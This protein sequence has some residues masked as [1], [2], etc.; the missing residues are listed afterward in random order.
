MN[1]SLGDHLT[2]DDGVWTSGELMD[3][4]IIHEV[5]SIFG[6]STTE[7][8]EDEE[9][10]EEEDC[11]E[12]YQQPAIKEATNA[13]DTLRRFFYGANVEVDC[14]FQ[15]LD[16]IERILAVVTTKAKKQARITDYFTPMQ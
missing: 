5:R 4:D 14:I 8:N 7:E 6:V 1:V 15:K 12:E 9:E 16:E 3:S 10:E 2:A 13:M 11:G